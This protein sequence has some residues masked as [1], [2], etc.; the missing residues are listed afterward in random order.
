VSAETNSTTLDDS[1]SNRTPDIAGAPVTVVVVGQKYDFVPVAT[2]GDDDA[3]G[4][5]IENRP[6]WAT[7]DTATGR[8]SGTPSVSNVG[9]FADIRISVSDGKA[10][11]SMA[12]FSLTVADSAPPAAASG[13]ATLSWAAPTENTDGSALTDLAGYRIRYGTSADELTQEIAINTVGLTTY[14]VTD[15]APATYYFAVKSVSK[16]GAESTLSGM[17]SKTIG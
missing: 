13:T 16:S 8:L 2:D 1:A 3:L 17:A 14:T 5:T 12:D 11:A 15:L 9:S 7:F 10:T 6:G 4:F